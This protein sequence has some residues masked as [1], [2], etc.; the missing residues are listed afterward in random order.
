MTPFHRVLLIS[1]LAALGAG[2]GSEDASDASEAPFGDEAAAWSSQDPSRFGKTDGLGGDPDAYVVLSGGFGSC[3][4]YGPHTMGSFQSL[5]IMLAEL[6]E[7]LPEIRVGFLVSCLVRDA[8]PGGL[9]YFHINGDSELF[10]T[11]AGVLHEVIDLLVPDEASV[12]LIGH[13]YGGWLAIHTFLALEEIHRREVAALFTIDP[14]SPKACEPDLLKHIFLG[15][16][17][18]TVNLGSGGFLDPTLLGGCRRAPNEFPPDLEDRT[19]HHNFYQQNGG[20][21]QSGPMPGANNLEVKRER[22]TT[23]AYSPRVWDRIRAT[24]EADLTRSTTGSD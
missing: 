22:H 13:S 19:E 10:W 8:P 17:D 15:G 11:P 5:Q 4:D 1:A 18:V 3:G 21:I 16:F 6:N 9:A 12:Y 14:I 23:V 2:C 20:Y 24:I 7:A